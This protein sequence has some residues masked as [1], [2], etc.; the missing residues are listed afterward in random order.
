MAYEAIKA[1]LSQRLVSDGASADSFF[2][3]AVAASLLKRMNITI[4]SFDVQ[5]Q[6]AILLSSMNSNI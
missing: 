1:R 6:G 2:S 3:D 4:E 5:F